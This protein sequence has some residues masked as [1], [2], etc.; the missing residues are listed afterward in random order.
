MIVV[1]KLITFF[2]VS[3]LLPQGAGRDF[4]PRSPPGKTLLCFS[5]P[6]SS[7]IDTLGVKICHLRMQIFLV[8]N[9]NVNKT[10]KQQLDPQ[11]V[12]VE[13]GIPFFAGAYV[14]F[15]SSPRLGRKET[16]KGV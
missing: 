13:N 15:S 7:D 2:L 5:P 10:Q 1:H 14:R 4:P 16:R 8:Y 6:D 11:L 3:P 12:S 9:I